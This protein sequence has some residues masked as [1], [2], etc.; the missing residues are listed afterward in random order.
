MHAELQAVL[1][2]SSSPK[3]VSKS[4]IHALLM[5]AFDGASKAQMQAQEYHRLL[6]LAELA[7]HDHQLDG[8]L[9]HLHQTLG[10]IDRESA[11]L[12]VTIRSLARAFTQ[13]ERYL[14][15]LP[16]QLKN[17]G[18]TVQGSA[19]ALDVASEPTTD[20]ATAQ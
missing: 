13:W 15:E 20:H 4:D 19:D 3:H 16:D 8:K 17:L 12:V 9:E 10:A 14:A 1:V 2:E 11:A 7:P 5:P 6:G 18:L